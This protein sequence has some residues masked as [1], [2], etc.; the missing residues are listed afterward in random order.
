M[1]CLG[2]YS[3]KG[4]VRVPRMLGNQSCPEVIFLPVRDFLCPQGPLPHKRHCPAE[5]SECRL[6]ATFRAINQHC[7]RILL[8]RKAA[9]SLGNSPATGAQSVD[10]SETASCCIPSTRR[11]VDSGAVHHSI[12]E[13]KDAHRVAR[14]CADLL[15]PAAW[16]F[17]IWQGS[18]ATRSDSD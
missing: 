12:H 9:P 18:F 10:N 4:R 3:A 7:S 2:C 16:P 17:S 14:D 11:F 13:S 8:L 15:L 5:F 1:Q 6:H